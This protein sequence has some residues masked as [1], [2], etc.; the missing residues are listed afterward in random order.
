[1]ADPA[2][3]GLIRVVWIMGPP[4]GSLGFTTSLPITPLTFQY[5]SPRQAKGSSLTT[6]TINV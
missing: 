4:L 5:Y 6:T 2:A 1:M 3:A